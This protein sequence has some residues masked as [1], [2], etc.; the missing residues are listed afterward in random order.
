MADHEKRFDEI[1][2]DDDQSITEE[3]MHSH[4]ERRR[5]QHRGEP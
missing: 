2:A 3:E 5:D 4:H 1:D